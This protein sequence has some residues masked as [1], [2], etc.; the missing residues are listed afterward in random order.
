[1]FIVNPEFPTHRAHSDTVRMLLGLREK[2][3]LPREGMP[4]R[5]IQGIEVWVTP[6][7]EREKGARWKR[8]THRVLA[9]CPTCGRVLSVG[10]LHQHRCTSL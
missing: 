5:L 10:R 6:L 8:S 7:P 3:K 9:K 4:P 2:E 1:M